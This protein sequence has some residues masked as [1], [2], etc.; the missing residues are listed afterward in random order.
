MSYV[1][2]FGEGFSSFVLK[3]KQKKMQFI[4]GNL[5]H[6]VDNFCIAFEFISIVWKNENKTRIDNC[7]SELKLLPYSQL[8][9]LNI[10]CRI[11]KIISIWISIAYFSMNQ[12]HLKQNSFLVQLM[13]EN[14]YKN[15]I[16][17]AQL[18]STSFSSSQISNI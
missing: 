5:I 11:L 8:L 9:L 1:L 18:I 17:N 12:F 6:F 15:C 3:L 14:K 2:F 13:I 10:N 4:F 16:L 7:K